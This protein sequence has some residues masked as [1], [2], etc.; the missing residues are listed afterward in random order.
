M[1]NTLWHGAVALAVCLAVP[2][3]ANAAIIFDSFD[4]L[5]QTAQSFTTTGSTPRNFMADD[6]STIALPSPNLDW[7]VNVLSFRLFAAGSGAA[8]PPATPPPVTYSNVTA[9]VRVFNDFNATA[10]AGTSVFSDLVSNVIWTLGDITNNSATGGGQVFTFNLPYE[11]AGLDFRLDDGQSIGISIDL[12]SGGIANQGLALTL[13][14]VSSDPSSA[15]PLAGLPSI[16]TSTNGWYRDANSN[17]IIEAGDRRTLGGTNSNV[18][19]RIDA[20]AV[21]EP[22]SLAVLA[23][24]AVGVGLRRI[25]RRTV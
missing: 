4:G 1:K 23:V 15:Q 6:L 20:V 10:A 18:H 14:S 12:L 19:F 5:N 24:G 16:G 13:R 3:T 21:P 22:A 8:T 2:R 17:G 7:Q 11:A 25:R 9:Q